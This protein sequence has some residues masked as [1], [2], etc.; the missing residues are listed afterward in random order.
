MS[1]IVFFVIAIVSC[2]YLYNP[3]TNN[4]KIHYEIISGYN[5]QSLE[6]ELTV[7]DYFEYAIEIVFV[8]DYHDSYFDSL[9]KDQNNY[10][11]Y[12]MH[13]YNNVD[14][15]YNEVYICSY[16]PYLFY[17]IDDYDNVDFDLIHD[18]AD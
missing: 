12:N 5:I 14:M 18:I 9:N 4:S 11:V 1:K 3:S 8:L 2:I 13:F 7:D 10:Y 6:S 17:T 15:M 16:T